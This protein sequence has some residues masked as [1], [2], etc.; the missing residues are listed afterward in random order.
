MA[1]KKILDEYNTSS[2]GF[3]SIILLC[4]LCG[5]SMNEC[6]SSHYRLKMNEIKYKNFMDSINAQKNDSTAYILK[7]EKTR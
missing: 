4:A 3:L 6:Q 5:L 2:H 1:D 7:N